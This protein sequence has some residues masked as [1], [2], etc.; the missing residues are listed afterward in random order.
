MSPMSC[1]STRLGCA[2]L[3]FIA[4]MT[5]VAVFGTPAK[6]A[7]PSATTH[8]VD[9]DAAAH[10]RAITVPYSSFA[11]EE[12]RIA[13]A[14]L[15]GDEH[16]APEGDADISVR[17]AYY[18]RFNSALAHRAEEIYPVNIEPQTLGGVKVEVITPKAGVTA[19]QRNRV[20]INLH[21][22]AFLWG[23]GSGGEIESIP[24]AG[25][26]RI[27][28]ITVAYRQGPEFKFPAASEDVATV[29]RAL[30]KDHQAKS[31]GIYGCSAGGILTA[32][33]V[34]WLQKEHLP[35][36]GAVGIFCASAGKF[37]GD[38]TFLAPELS[39]QTPL[40]GSTEGKLSFT[41]YFSNVS[42][43]D[44]LVLPMNSKQVLSRFPPTLLIAGSRDFA[45]SSVCQ[46]DLELTKVGV[47]TELHIW[48]GLWHSFFNNPDL[49]E[50]TEMY[51][52]VVKFF[53]RYL[54]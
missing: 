53:D 29:Y 35:M 7:G 37:G 12:A 8:Y 21:G 16:H 34:A 28:V 17:R 11:T 4:V 26:G 46:T 45:L 19:R 14:H 2:T 24:I 9:A 3:A 49:P 54:E 23:E 13:Y 39:A 20:L 1:M 18:D 51:S 48:D 27:T 41:P 6:A 33:A 5:N 42:L 40:P 43:S 30:L 50:S 10:I 32:E 36:P 47:K 31:I 22:G 38:S 25:L 15:F 44:P 52:M